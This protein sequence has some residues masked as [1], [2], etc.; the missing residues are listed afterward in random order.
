[1]YY[2]AAT[3]DVLSLSTS[4]LANFL[5]ADT[6]GVVTFVIDYT[7][8]TTFHQKESDSSKPA[9]LSWQ[10]STATNLPPVS[11]AGSDQTVTDSNGDGYESVTLNGAGSSDDGT[12]TSYVWT[13]NSATI[14]TGKTPVVNFAVGTHTV[15]LTVTDDGGKTA[16]D[17]VVI[18]VKA[19]TSSGLLTIS[20]EN[21]EIDSDGDPAS[22]GVGIRVVSSSAAIG[23]AKVGYT[24][25]GA[26]TK[27]ASVD[28]DG[29]A[30]SIEVVA[31]SLSTGGRLAFRLGSPTGLTIAEVT[32]PV[33]GGWN[34]FQTI[35]SPVTGDTAG[36]HDVYMVVVSA[37][38]DIDEF[39]FV[40]GSTQSSDLYLANFEGGTQNY[41]NLVLT[42]VDGTGAGEGQ[43]P[44][45]GSLYAWDTLASAIPLPAGI[46]N[47]KLN[48]DVK[49]PSAELGDVRFEVIVVF[50]QSTGSPSKVMGGRLSV[51]SN[52]VGKWAT[53][54]DTVAI[55]AGAVSISSVRI[56]FVQL[57]SSA[58]ANT[59]YVDNI[60]VRQ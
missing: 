37:G 5:N 6:N 51:D 13:A 44:A 25:N 16:S 41:S 14:A 47:L 31:S 1:M 36:V 38:I 15:T 46:T 23:G 7:G 40:T 11:R 22:S 50:N 21:Y 60:R 58:G 18:S 9:A 28:F 30:T 24:S 8:A 57:N 53:Y 42:S 32:V 45:T 26:W 55:P 56:K 52:F 43:V 27:Y 12:I 20:A 17:T 48:A 49:L 29:G 19:P 3:S 10:T 4:A 2:T 33:T 35:T 54:E 39:R 34:T 59:V